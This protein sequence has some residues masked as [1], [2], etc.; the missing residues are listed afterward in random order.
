MPMSLFS[1]FNQLSSSL[2]SAFSNTRA[3]SQSINGFTSGLGRVASQA[4]SFLSG[5]NNITRA[6]GGITDTARNIKNT[7]GAVDVLIN[8]GQGLGNIGSA[9]R[10]LSNATQDVGFNAAPRSRKI[11][12]AIISKDISTADASDWR[13]SLSVPEI[14]MKGNVLLPLAGTGNR[15]VFPFNP[16][17]LIGHTA[18][19]SNIQPTHTNYAMYAYENSQVDQITITGEFFNENE[20]DAQYWIACLH[21][22]R[23]MTK[24][25]Y[26]ASSEALGNPPAVARL[27]GYGKFVLNNI[28]VILTNFTT[29]MPADV[30][31]IECVVDGQ[32]NY[33]PTQSTITVTVQPNY[34]RRSHS[35]FSL[36][37]YIEGNHT[38]TSEGFV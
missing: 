4:Q 11:S 5:N 1:G 13:V 32:S 27:N 37:D 24:M 25:F 15:M 35:R 30:D 22:L 8:G 18:N 3:T 2:S 9:L 23:I 20:E 29:D 26:G 19:Y 16:T 38:Q 34:A 28:P 33:V 7:I 6:L 10:M 36:Q 14:I 21:Y 31:Y 12:R 17:I